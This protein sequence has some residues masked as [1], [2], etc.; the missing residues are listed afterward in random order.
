MSRETS[1][2]PTT[3]RERYVILDATRGF[4]LAGI[5]LAN[6]PEFSLWTFLPDEL[7]ESMPSAQTDAIVR[8]M[9]YLLIDAKFYTI[10]SL[11]F[12]LGFALFIERAML[13]GRHALRLFWRRMLFLALIGL[14]HLLF[15]WSGDILLLYALGGMCLPLLRGLSGRNMLRLAALLLLLPIAI[16]ALELWAGWELS[17][18]MERAW[19]SHAEARGINEGNFHTWL[20][21][22]TSYAQ[23]WDFLVQGAYERMYEFL[24]GHRLLKVLG[25]F[26]IGYH[27]GRQKLYQNL[28]SH[29][30]AIK[31]GT[32]L[33]LGVGLPCS[34]LYAWSCTHGHPWGTIVHSIL[35]ALSA[36]P[37][38]AAYV[39]LLALL[40]IR[41]ERSRLF[42]VLAAPGRMALSCYLG[43]SVAGCALFYGI[44]LGW[45]TTMG[46]TAVEFTAAMVFFAETLLCLLWLTRY[47]FGPAEWVWRMLTYGQWLPLK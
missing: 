36:Y 6:F 19:W 5:C 16:D 33:L 39:G 23:V 44:G 4:A 8:F 37:M 38:G 3:G 35:Y 14:V 32:Q 29:Q 28:P 12:G 40:Y 15:I 9:Q 26:L 22:A 45:G 34:T 7:R 17:S 11:L 31:K 25:L 1:A 20:R 42:T 10:F 24:D 2:S 30:Q 18:P 21:D 47:R 41:H 27:V 13:K 43:Q 46:L